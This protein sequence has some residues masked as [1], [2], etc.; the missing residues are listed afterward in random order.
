MELREQGPDGT[1]GKSDQP[2]VSPAIRPVFSRPLVLNQ[3]YDLAR[4]EADIASGLA[5]AIAFGRPFI[6]NPD[7]VDRLRVG[8]PLAPDVMATWYSQGPE[9]YIDYPELAQAA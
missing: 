8:A 4:A 3:D 2:K 9:G 7:L 6:S 5:D 1:F